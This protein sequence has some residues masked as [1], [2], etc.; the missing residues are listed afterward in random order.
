MVT[1]LHR[2][3][4]KQDNKS[5]S[6]RN[7][8][9]LMFASQSCHKIDEYGKILNE[10]EIV[11]MQNEDLKNKLVTVMRSN[12][13]SKQPTNVSNMLQLLLDSAKINAN[14][15]P[16]GRRYCTVIKELAFIIYSIGGLSIYE[17]LSANLCLPSISNVRKQIYKFYKVLIEGEFRIKELK[18][19]LQERHY[20]LRVHI[21]E[22]AT[23]VNGRIQYH[24][25]TN[26][27]VG[28]T[29]PLD[30]DGIPIVGSYLTSSAEK[31]C[32]YFDECD[33]SNYVYCI[34]AQPLCDNASVFCLAM[35]G[36]N[37]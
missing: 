9:K 26:Q 16:N 10:M 37:N 30:S 29:L 4:T 12:S 7:Q 21:S 32:N 22:D 24:S 33:T 36:T 14:I 2:T 19:F 11:L 5:R 13:K 25:A 27:V 17:I 31:M 34:I 8:R 28:F 6:T 3:K 20:P 23:R 1:L 18:L 15:N 35:F